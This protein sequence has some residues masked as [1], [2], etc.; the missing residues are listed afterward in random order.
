M[1]EIILIIAI[2]AADLA[3]KHWAQNVLAAMPNGLIVWRDVFSFHYVQ[4]TGAAFGI[5][6]NARWLF[7]IITVPVIL[8]IAYILWKKRPPRLLSLALAAILAGAAGNLIDRVVFTYV[9]DFISVDLIHFAVFNV[10]DMAVCV[11]GVILVAML[12]FYKKPLFPDRKRKK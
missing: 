6:P 4:N 11:G 10:A 9:R 2:L 12:L 1:P 7:L 5:L 3:T 8:L